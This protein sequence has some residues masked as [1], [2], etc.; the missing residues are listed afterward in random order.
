M[1]KKKKRTSLW[2]PIT[3]EDRD[4]MNKMF[5]SLKEVD[6]KDIVKKINE[7]YEKYNQDLRAKAKT[8]EELTVGLE[9]TVLEVNGYQGS[10]SFTPRSEMMIGGSS[11]SY[12]GGHTYRTEIKVE[13]GTLVEKLNFKGW[14][15]LEAGDGIRAYILKGQEEAER[16]PFS[17]INF[18]SDPKTHWVERD[19]QPVEHPAKIEKLRNG[20]VVSTYHNK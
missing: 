1:T 19:Y 8:K 5:M 7:E 13:S 15:H 9:C 2:D 14:L 4:E 20:K 16:E 11:P 17:G 10:T 6:P 18:H 3:A 12:G